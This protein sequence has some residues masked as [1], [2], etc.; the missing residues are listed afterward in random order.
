MTDDLY[1][2]PIE[3]VQP[4]SMLRRHQPAQSA[5]PATQTTYLDRTGKNMRQQNEANC[6]ADC[7]SRLLDLRCGTAWH[8]KLRRHRLVTFRT[9]L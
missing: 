5:A 2:Q 9:R 4:R 8:Q 7:C 3:A 6:L 1:R